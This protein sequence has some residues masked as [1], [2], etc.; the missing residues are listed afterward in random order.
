M[1]SI[2][3]LAPVSDNIT[4]K[5][6]QFRKYIVLPYLYSSN[7]K[8]IELCG[9]NATRHQYN[10]SNC[11]FDIV[12]VTGIGHGSEENFYVVD[13]IKSNLENL[14]NYIDK[15]DLAKNKIFHFFSCKTAIKLGGKLV[16]KGA[17]SFFG[18]SI[19]VGAIDNEKLLMEVINCDAQ[20]DIQLSRG[21][22]VQKAHEEAIKAY[23]KCINYYISIGK[24]RWAAMFIEHRDNLCSPV[25]NIK[26]GNKSDRL[27]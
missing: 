10:L 20:I 24:I 6:Y 26:Y 5:G 27:F 25:T 15:L 4:F 1:N 12:Y 18:Y 7:F 16:R 2:I 23:D 3:F 11:L 21:N 14:F 17:K 9:F 22:T 13:P 8:V 19:T